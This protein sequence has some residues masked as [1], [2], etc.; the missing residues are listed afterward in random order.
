MIVLLLCALAFCLV[1]WWTAEL[2]ELGIA[3]VFAAPILQHLF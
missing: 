2:P 1:L 3:I